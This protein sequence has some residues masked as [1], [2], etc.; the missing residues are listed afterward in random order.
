MQRP[1]F[2]S[3]LAINW[4]QGLQRLPIGINESGGES[5]IIKSL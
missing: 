1:F 2:M 5:V 4:K 3:Y